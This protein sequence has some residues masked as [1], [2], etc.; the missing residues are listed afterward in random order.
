[1][2]SRYLDSAIRKDVLTLSQ[3]Q[4]M[5]MQ[6]FFRSSDQ[7]LSDFHEIAQT[8]QIQN[9]RA[10][11]AWEVWNSA[12]ERWA[13]FGDVSAIQT[14]NT[15]DSTLHTRGVSTELS[16][17]KYWVTAALTRDLDIGLLYVPKV[18]PTLAKN[19]W[20]DFS[21]FGILA[22]LLSAL[23]ATM[24]GRRTGQHLSDVAESIRSIHDIDEDEDLAISDLPL[25]IRNVVNALQE[26]L[27]NIRSERD[28]AMVMTAGLAHELRSPIQN[29]MG[30]TEVALLRDNDAERYRM[31]LKGQTEELRGLARVVDNLVMLCTRTSTSEV[32]EE[33]DIGT[34]ASIRLKREQSRAEEH[35][36]RIQIIKRGSLLCQG[37]REAIML[38]L[39]NLV[40]NAVYWSPWGSQVDVSLQGERRHITMTVDDSGP[41]VP[42]SERDAIF[43][44][45]FQGTRK[46][47]GHRI[48]YGLGLALTREAVAAHNGSVTVTD[49]PFGGA[50]FEIFLPRRFSAEFIQNDDP[51]RELDMLAS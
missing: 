39:S 32:V 16:N 21:G 12:G 31:I 51:E 49:S 33:F 24:I 9:P 29:L 30:T 23:G 1:M 20:L 18:Q 34:E 38:A 37:D 19:F 7:T 42:E 46:T 25:E 41:G 43:Q 27:E 35:S 28:R 13:Y 50:R 26:M 48:G 8:V 5:S 15:Q 45:F 2:T 11:L 17:G 47:E 40:S 10:E 14:T 6:Y 36:I 22:L 3:G 44:P 4:L